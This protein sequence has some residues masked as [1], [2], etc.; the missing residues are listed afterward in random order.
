MIE[1]PDLSHPDAFEHGFPH[2]L[3]RRLRHDA[4]VAWHEGGWA[5]PDPVLE[6]R[7]GEPHVR[8]PQN[9]VEGTKAILQYHGTSIE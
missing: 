5:K 1:I 2:E 8:Q 4:P 9:I 7:K 3:F 6:W